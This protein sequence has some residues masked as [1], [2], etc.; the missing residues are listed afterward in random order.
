MPLN[1][2]IFLLALA[3]VETGGRDD[4]VGAHGERGRWQ[5]S[6]VV[7]RQHTKLPFKRAHYE[8]DA[9]SVARKHVRW[10][11][12]Q[13]PELNSESPMVIALVWNA[14]LNPKRGYSRKTCDFGRRVAN[15][16]HEEL[17]L[18]NAQKPDQERFLLVGSTNTAG[19]KQNSP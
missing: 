13:V 5:I 11:Q 3:T 4:A 15:L 9:F 1:L 2:P 8:H 14:G 18:R 7:W 19:T 10:I 6:S 12:R 16:Y 17:R